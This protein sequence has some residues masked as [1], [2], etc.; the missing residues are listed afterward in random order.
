MFVRSLL[1]LSVLTEGWVLPDTQKEPNT[2]V[3]HNTNVKRAVEKIVY[4]Y[5]TDQFE[6]NEQVF[7]EILYRLGVN[8]ISRPLNVRKVKQLSFLN[9]MANSRSRHRIQKQSLTL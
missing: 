4:K 5:I 6:Y 9:S 1:L 7:Y 3:D 2:S 8:V